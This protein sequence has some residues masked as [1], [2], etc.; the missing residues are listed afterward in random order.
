[1][2]I[3]FNNFGIPSVLSEA[4]ERGIPTYF[5]II[6]NTD[7]TTWPMRSRSWREFGLE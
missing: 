7:T 2:L 3:H 4:I 6:L 5:E 1:L